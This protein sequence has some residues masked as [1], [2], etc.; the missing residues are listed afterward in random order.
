[1]Q[2]HVVCAC[3]AALIGPA[4]PGEAN[5]RPGD[6][7]RLA[8]RVFATRSLANEHGL[9]SLSVRAGTLPGSAA[10]AAHAP[11][12]H[13]TIAP[14]PESRK[15]MSKPSPTTPHRSC[16][17]CDARAA[18]LVVEWRDFHTDR[19]W[20]KADPSLRL[21]LGE[22]AECGMVYVTN[23]DEVDMTNTKYIHH[24]PRKEPK[25]VPARSKRLDY[26]RAQMKMLSR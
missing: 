10:D 9:W 16:P 14:L 21:L 25:A 7:P 2:R 26:H 4:A 22:C 15:P 1:M 20:A 5:R 24:R 13:M 17:N 3:R 18:R 23:S 19:C 11:A 8:N 12:V 6:A